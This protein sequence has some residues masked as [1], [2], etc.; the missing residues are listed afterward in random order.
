L[1]DKIQMQVCLP[2]NSRGSMMNS[3]LIDALALMRAEEGV[4]FVGQRPLSGESI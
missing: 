1:F 2:Q 4:N 3:I